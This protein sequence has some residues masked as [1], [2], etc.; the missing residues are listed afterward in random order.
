MDIAN[1]NPT[2]RQVKSEEAKSLADLKHMIGA[3]ET[4]AKE[5]TN[6]TRTFLDLALKLREKNERLSSI[7]ESEKS[8]KLS[9]VN[10]KE[11]K[12]CPC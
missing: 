4:S 1:S 7:G 8:I 11:E 12:R 6:I 10:V 5:D 2:R 3:I 9:T